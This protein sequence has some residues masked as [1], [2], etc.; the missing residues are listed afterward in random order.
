MTALTSPTSLPKDA[1]V[2]WT[3]AR[4][5]G[6]VD[7]AQLLEAGLTTAAIKHRAAAGWLHRKHRRV[8]A[9]GHAG[10]TQRGCWMAA[11]LSG[12]DE[13]VLSH[14][15]AGALWGI[16]LDAPF[17]EITAPLHSRSGRIV[18][19]GAIR[20]GDTLI[21]DGIRVTKVGRTLLDL[22]E[23]LSLEQ[24]VDAIDKAT[25]TRRLGRG[26]MSSVIKSSRGRRG[27]K[28]LKQALLITRPQDVLTRSELERRALRLIRRGRLEPPEVN[29]RL[30]G[31]EV[32]LLWRAQRLVVELDS[33]EHH[34]TDTAQD[35]DTRRTGNLRKHGYT[36]LR[37]TWRQV[38]NDPDWVT[39]VLTP[40][41]ELRGA[42]T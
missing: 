5:H 28:P 39:S 21:V 12:G 2:A 33:R 3:A 14:R 27:L 23:V 7:H 18:H 20:P 10:L 42:T 17:P 37:F 26:T 29:V 4:Q 22:A 38:V 31:Y 9:V 8:Y 15:S 34:G 1:K 19:K 25:N 11:V 13:A 30:H 6:V 32:D 35:R 41:G 40:G 36:T 24:L 16:C